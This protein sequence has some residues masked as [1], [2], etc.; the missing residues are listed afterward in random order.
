MKAP[1]IRTRLT[2]WY[3][4]ALLVVLSASAAIVVWQQGRIGLRTVDRELDDLAATLSNVLRDELGEMPTAKAA[5][6]E[7]RKTMAGPGHA[8]AILDDRKQVLASTWTGPTLAG[9]G[10]Q[11]S[12]RAAVWSVRIAD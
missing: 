7:V 9:Q 6:E 3:S 8:V 10:T 12:G 5:A 1:S 4:L 11:S 2:V